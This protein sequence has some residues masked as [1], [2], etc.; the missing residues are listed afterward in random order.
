[1]SMISI[2]DYAAKVG[3]SPVSVRQK[4]ARGAIPGA[5]K[6]GRDWLIPEDAPYIDLRIKQPGTNPYQYRYI[7]VQRTDMTYAIIGLNHQEDEVESDYMMRLK[8]DPTVRQFRSI[9]GDELQDILKATMKPD[10]WHEVWNKLY[11]MDYY[12]HIISFENPN[13]MTDEEFAKFNGKDYS[14]VKEK[15][16]KLGY[17]HEVWILDTRLIWKYAPWRI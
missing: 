12:Q 10:E 3:R 16:K 8:Q 15:M 11:T 13:Y 2:N 9:H 5:V 14:L 4:A 17:L 7:L 1:M 6:I